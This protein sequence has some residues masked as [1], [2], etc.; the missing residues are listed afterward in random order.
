[1][2]YFLSAVAFFLVIGAQA[3]AAI[4]VSSSKRESADPMQ[5]ENE[6]AAPHADD[7]L[8]VR[9]RWQFG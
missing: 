4:A 5:R 3:A 8:G 6:D 7:Q 1:M 2:E 9:R